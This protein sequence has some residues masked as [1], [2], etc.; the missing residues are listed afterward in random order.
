MESPQGSQGPPQP[1]PEQYQPPPRVQRG[2]AGL[3][4]I[5]HG[6]FLRGSIYLIVGQP[7]TGKTILSNQV[8]FNHVASGGKAVFVSVLSETHSRL[9]GHLSP[10]SFFDQEPIG[11]SLLYISG[12]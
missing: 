5:L 1:I 7:G 4:T 2:I 8:V 3:D 11:N 9:F 6:G 12:Y 10:L